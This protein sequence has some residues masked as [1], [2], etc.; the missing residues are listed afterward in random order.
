MYPLSA[1]IINHE[2]GGKSILDK[3]TRCRFSGMVMVRRSKVGH[4]G[5][6]PANFIVRVKLSEGPSLPK[7]RKGLSSLSQLGSGHGRKYQ[8]SGV[9]DHDTIGSKKEMAWTWPQPHFFAP[10]SHNLILPKRKTPCPLFGS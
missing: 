6:H 4:D 5:V 3:G 8:A 2:T 9:T 7:V 10:N 1:R